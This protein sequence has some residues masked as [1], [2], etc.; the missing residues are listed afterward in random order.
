MAQYIDLYWWKDLSDRYDEDLFISMSK[1]HHC[2]YHILSPA[3]HLDSLRERG[4]PLS[5]PD[6]Y[7]QILV[8]VSTKSFLLFALC[9]TLFR[10]LLWIPVII[11]ACI[12]VFMCFFMFFCT[13]TLTELSLCCVRLSHFVIKFDWLI[14]LIIQNV[15]NYNLFLLTWD[16]YKIEYTFDVNTLTKWLNH[17]HLSLNW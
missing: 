14:E 8:L 10:L 17:I 3:G 1:A 12:F 13:V 5:L 4:H 7:Y 9:I 11:I 15:V 2:L 16:I 6:K